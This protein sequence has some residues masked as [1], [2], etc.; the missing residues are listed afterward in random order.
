MEIDKW[1]GCYRVRSFPWIDG[2]SIYMNVQYFAPGQ[3]IAQLPVWDKS[4]YIT[5]NPTGQRIVCEFTDSLVNYV[6]R[7]KIPEGAKVVLTA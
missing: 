5:D 1:F 4:V 3:S 6:A 7:M 2:K